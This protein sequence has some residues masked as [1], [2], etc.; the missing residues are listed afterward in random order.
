M[1]S[2]F[3]L[4]WRLYTAHTAQKSEGGS[5]VWHL[6][7]FK[8][9][10]HSSTDTQIVENTSLK[11]IAWG[12]LPRLRLQNKSTLR[13]CKKPCF[14]YSSL[15]LRTEWQLYHFQSLWE[16]VKSCKKLQPHKNTCTCVQCKLSTEPPLK[17][18][19]TQQGPSGNMRRPR[20]QV[21]M[22]PQTGLVINL[23]IKSTKLT[24]SCLS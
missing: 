6:T 19:V 18:F 17:P 22:E 9:T 2:V 13:P 5:I 16:A 3:A 20:C 12:L 14:K 24:F 4:M 11:T 23:G 7:Q 15:Q 21:I 1:V 8:E 10:H